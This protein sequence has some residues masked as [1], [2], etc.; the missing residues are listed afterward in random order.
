MRRSQAF[1]QKQA[2][3]RQLLL[4]W[5]QGD[6]KT[7]GF[8]ASAN[9]LPEAE[10]PQFYDH[11][12]HLITVAPTRS[13]KG[14]G[15]IVPNLL[16]Y[17]GPVVVL[18]PKGENYQITARRRQEMGQQV[19]KVD[20]FYVL[21]DTT[22]GMNPFDVFTLPRADIVSDGQMLAHLLAAGNTN[23]REPFWDLNGCG[24]L[25]GVIAYIATVKE[26]ADRNLN[27]VCKVLTSDDVVYN[28]A[29]VLDTVGKRLK[30]HCYQEIA[31][32]LQMP[33]LTRGGVLATAESYLRPF[34][35]ERVEAAFA[36]SSFP[37]SDVVDG[38]PLSIYLILPPDKL[39]SHKALLK[40]W[41]GMLL[42][43]IT[44]RTE[45]PA[46]RT[47]F[48]LDEC[49]QLGNFPF[50]ETM[51][52]LSA[53]YGVWCWS[54]WQDLSQLKAAYPTNWENILN[55]CGVVQTFGIHNR[56]MAQ[57]WG[58]YLHHDAD[59]LHGLQPEEQV[60][61]IHGQP[62]RRSRRMDYLNDPLFKGQFDAN[63]FFRRERN[64][65]G[66]AIEPG[67]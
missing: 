47:L 17:E 62:E 2:N 9:P 15:V 8:G 63:R 50:L 40:L 51:I 10:E 60:V 45:A 12:A 56:A 4:G 33:D 14:R 21:D 32:F 44:S 7:F 61:A 22:D 57:Q 24:L 13:G 35:S 36:K 52:T 34:L 19:V 28:L 42:K 26:P 58:Q 49:S 25:T 30:K 39:Q 29:V 46:L 1:R 27:E 55:N 43:A 54:F 31:S 3:G 18:D 48:L 11:D 23:G 5:P 53:G 38:K 41:V 66:T 59:T 6:A 20:P 64:G 37:L 65:P 16:H 67:S